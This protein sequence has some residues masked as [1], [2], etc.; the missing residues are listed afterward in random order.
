MIIGMGCDLVDIR[1]IENMLIKYDKKFINR[2]FAKS[3]VKEKLDTQK[4]ACFL[5]KR[6]AAKEALVKALGLGFRKG[7]KWND[8]CLLNNELGKPYIQLNGEAATQLK[9]LGKQYKAVKLPKIHVSLSD[10]PP[11]AQAVVILEI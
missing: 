10:E 3:E 8:I 2:I 4:L 1:R 6:F 7:I 5:A 11:Y 9:F